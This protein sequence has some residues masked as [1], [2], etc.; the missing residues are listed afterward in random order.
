MSEMLVI[1]ELVVLDFQT[2]LSQH[3]ICP[4]KLA[5]A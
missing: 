5:Y 1:A 2:I 3:D 4:Q